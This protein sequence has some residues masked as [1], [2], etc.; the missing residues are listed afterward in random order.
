MP[1]QIIGKYIEP[2]FYLKIET[3]SGKKI[4]KTPQTKKRIVQENVAC[5]VQQILTEPVLGEQGTA[6]YCK[7]PNIDVAAKTGTT[8][9]NYDRWLCGFTPYYTAVCWYGFDLNE[10]IETNLKTNPAGLI[11][12]NVMKSIHKNLPQASFEIPQGVITYTICRDTGE[13]ATSR[14]PDTYTEYFVDDIELEYCNK[15]H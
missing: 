14:C 15:N 2:T 5:V 13:K 10:S 1:L 4:F 3:S 7:I 12:S 6:T 9:E 11:W 8:N